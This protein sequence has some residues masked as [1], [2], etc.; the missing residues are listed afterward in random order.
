MR[1]IASRAP[2][3]TR[4]ASSPGSPRTVNTDRWWSG[5]EEWWIRPGP[6]A[7]A[8]AATAS[9]SRPSE[10]LGTARS[11][12]VSYQNAPEPAA[13]SGAFSGGRACGGSGV[14]GDRR[15]HPLA[16][17]IGDRGGP[18]VG[19]D[20]GRA[21][22]HVREH[23]GR[24][25][26]GGRH[27]AVLVDRERRG[28]D[29]LELAD[30][31]LAGGPLVLGRPAEPDQLGHVVDAGVADHVGGGG[32]HAGSSLGAELGCCPLRRTDRRPIPSD[33]SPLPPRFGP[34]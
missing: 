26:E 10:T 17:A 33:T 32:K 21:G 22:A 11:R 34:R 13:G 4:W 3:I 7:A 20:A 29:A 9:V 15:M 12:R 18:P 28:D 19:E 27:G 5:S 8:M 16:D 30:D 25:R 2:S 23:V 24:A 1:A 6:K 31:D 14:D